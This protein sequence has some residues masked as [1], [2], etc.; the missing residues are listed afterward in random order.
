MSKKI[1][2]VD[3]RE[4]HLLSVQH[5]LQESDNEYEF[6]GAS[7]GEQCINILKSGIRPDVILLDIMMPEMSG[8]LVFDTIRDN[9]LWK[10][11]PIMFVTAR[12][13]KLA[14][15]TGRFLA[16]DYIEKPIDERLIDRIE[17]ILK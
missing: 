17:K 4:D 15:E 6:I 1:M 2:F 16:E 14:E 11:I 10:D 7:S 5:L 12:S 13:D 9:P 3:D 8:W